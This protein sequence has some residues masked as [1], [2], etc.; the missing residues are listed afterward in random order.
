MA[1]VHKM[2]VSKTIKQSDGKNKREPIGVAEVVIFDLSEFAACIAAPDSIDSDSNLPVYTDLKLAFLQNAVISAILAKAR[3]AL[4]G[5]TP[6][7]GQSLATTIEELIAPSQTSG[8]FMVLN[9]AFEKAFAQYLAEHSGKKEAVQQLFSSLVKLTVRSALANAS[10]ARR[11]ALRTQL[12]GFTLS[13]NEEDTASY[14]AIITGLLSLCDGAEEVI[15]DD[16]L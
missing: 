14:T 2:A 12:E 3:N 1:T 15:S 9:S 13:L 4:D 7:A 16:D 8:G 5:I 6:K 10:L 11:D